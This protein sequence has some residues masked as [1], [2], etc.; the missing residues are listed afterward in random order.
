MQLNVKSFALVTNTSSGI[1]K[2]QKKAALGITKP[3]QSLAFTH[4]LGMQKWSH[5]G[6][7]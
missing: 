4:V 2:T 1:C 6:Q 7:L 3:H 5:F